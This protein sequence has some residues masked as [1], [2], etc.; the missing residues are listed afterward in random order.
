MRGAAGLRTDGAAR[1][2]RRSR[3]DHGVGV[4]SV[5][6]TGSDAGEFGELLRWSQTV[7]DLAGGDPAKGA[8]FGVGSPL[9]VALAFRGF[10]RW[11][12]GRPGWHQDLHHAVAM[13]RHGDPAILAL[14]VLWTYGL[15]IGYG[16]LRADD[17][18]MRA[19]EEAVHIAQRVSN[20]LPLGFAEYALGI[21][22]LYRDAAADRHRGLELMVQARDRAAR[23]C[24]LSCPGHRVVCRSG[25]GQ[26]R[27]P[28]SCHS[29]D[30]QSRERTAPG[31]TARLWRLGHRHTGGDAAGAWREGR[32]GR[33]QE[34]STGWRTCRQ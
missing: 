4:R 14:I 29:G 7:I 34:T 27:R 22:L 17:S 12:L 23:G 8:G 16:V 33:A 1:V 32:P 9:A 10:A 24:A 13:A 31:R 19:S 5:L 15:E 25:A 18:A 6:P 3:L 28:R 30:A 20:D 11:W 21:A 26:A 2:D